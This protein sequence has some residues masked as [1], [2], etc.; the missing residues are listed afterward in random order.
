[1]QK[2]ICTKE[3]LNSRI[4]TKDYKA[5]SDI[6]FTLNQV[7]IEEFVE[8]NYLDL[9]NL[10]KLKIFRHKRKIRLLPNG[11]PNLPVDW[12]KTRKGWK[13]GT[14]SK[15]KLIY[16]TRNWSIIFQWSKPNVK[17][18]TVYTFKPSRTNGKTSNV[19]MLNKLWFYLSKQDTNYLK[20]PM[21]N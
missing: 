18:I 9:P 6:W 8:K 17:N 16:H 15:D 19:G 3:L 2:T 12:I 11:K 13:D 20:I 5:Y 14:L 1:M 4:K 10:G 7:M 21:I